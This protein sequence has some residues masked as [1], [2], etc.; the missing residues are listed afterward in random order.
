[1]PSGLVA[2]MYFIYMLYVFLVL[3]NYVV[4][5]CPVFFMCIYSKLYCKW[6]RIVLSA[7]VFLLVRMVIYGF[8]TRH[9]G[10]QMRI[11][12]CVGSAR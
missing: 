3:E 1:M 4:V 12:L 6:Y 2:D 11:P 7:F 8:I 5:C 9:R 10:E